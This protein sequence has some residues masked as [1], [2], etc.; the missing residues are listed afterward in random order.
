MGDT[1]K[2]IG[3][4]L[5]TIIH[6][7]SSTAQSAWP[8]FVRSAQKENKSLYIFPGGQL[9]GQTDSDYLRNRIYS[10]VNSENLDG[11]ICWT[12]VIR[13]SVSAEEL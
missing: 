6:K 4:I 12:S 10:L 11:L 7:G 3:L 13:G 8:S 1:K 5:A 2:R 9:N